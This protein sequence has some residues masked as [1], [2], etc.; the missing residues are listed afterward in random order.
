LDARRENKSQ[1]EKIFIELPAFRHFQEQ[2]KANGLETPP[3]Q[4]LLRLVGSSK[5]LFKG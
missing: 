2:L 4:E 1:D 5:D 3:K